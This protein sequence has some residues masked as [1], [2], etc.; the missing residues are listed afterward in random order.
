MATNYINNAQLVKIAEINDI[1]SICREFWNKKSEFVIWF[2]CSDVASKHLP[3][4]SDEDNVTTTNGDMS[5]RG[6]SEVL[7]ISSSSGGND[8][9]NSSERHGSSSEVHHNRSIPDVH[10]GFDVADDQCINWSS[11]I[12]HFED[13]TIVS[14]ASSDS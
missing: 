1:N 8:D 10:L 13:I 14:K 7:P 12:D 4:D 11:H 9:S 2:I 3:L 6:V 5:Q